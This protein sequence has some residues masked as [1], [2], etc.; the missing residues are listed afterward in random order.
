MANERTGDERT[1]DVAERG[2]LSGG[3][4]TRLG[5]YTN[6]ARVSH[7]LD[8]FTLE[9]GV[10][11]SD[12][13]AGLHTKL[14]SSPSHAKRLLKALAQNIHRYEQTYGP[15]QEQPPTAQEKQERRTDVHR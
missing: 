7:T 12:K 9:F 5:V 11:V 1:G 4:P 10:K 2:P 6:V 14:I 15:I 13:L 8:E 3:V